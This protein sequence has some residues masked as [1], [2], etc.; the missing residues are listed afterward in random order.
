MINGRGGVNN[1]GGS[2]ICLALGK[3]MIVVKVVWYFC[4]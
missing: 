4:C 1:D 2:D 3:V